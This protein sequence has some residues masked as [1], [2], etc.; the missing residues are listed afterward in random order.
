VAESDAGQPVDAEMNGFRRLLASGNVEIVAT[1]RSRA[2]EY[3]VVTF[4]EQVLQ[5]T[6][7]LAA[8]QLDAEPEDVARFFVD[9]SPRAGGISG[10]A[11]GSCRRRGHRRRK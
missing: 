9:D 2:D 3:R 4:G 5:R 6:D 1:W 7:V 11:C 10:S 8:A